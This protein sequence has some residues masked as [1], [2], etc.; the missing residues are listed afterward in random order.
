M[1]LNIPYL[2][3][4]K[5][6]NKNMKVWTK[7]I[8]PPVSRSNQKLKYMPNILEIIAL[9]TEMIV[10]L[11]NLSVNKYA[12]APGVISIATTRTIPTDCNPT[13]ADKDRHVSSR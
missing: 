8:D 10:I 2:G 1:N 13:T 5:K 12:V 7:T 9:I 11:S 3:A 4:N 6:A